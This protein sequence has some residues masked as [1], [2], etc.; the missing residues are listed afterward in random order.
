VG[1]E[2]KDRTKRRTR[3]LSGRSGWLT[4]DHDLLQRF[5]GDHSAMSRILERNHLAAFVRP[6]TASRW[7]IS[8]SLQSTTRPAA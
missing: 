7:M 6:S 1:W 8:S 4:H 3:R 5:E 2:V